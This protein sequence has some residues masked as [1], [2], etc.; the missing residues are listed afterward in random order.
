VDAAE[1]EAMY[2]L[3]EQEVIPEFYE[4]ST[5]GL[6]AK[7]L[8]R[9]R[10]S[11]AL[12]TPE[13]SASRT[14]EDYT[15]DHYLPGALGYNQRVAGDGALATEILQWQKKLAQNWNAVRFDHVQ[16]QTH[17]GHH[18]FTVQVSPGSL[19]LSDIKVELFAAPTVLQEMTAVQKSADANGTITYTAQ[20]EATRPAGDYTP[21][22]LPNH[23]GAAVPLEANQILWQH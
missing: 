1:A 18:C 21:R 4:R 2:T 20:V 3:L 11:M 10:E 9:V 22:I 15:E 7:W 13:F 8:A 14:I 6:P 23:P 12:L 16:V 17:D 19:L 5:S